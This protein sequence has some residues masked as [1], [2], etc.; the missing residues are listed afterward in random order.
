M[1]VMLCL[2]PS[3]INS[4]FSQDITVLIFITIISSLASGTK[5]NLVSSDQLS[6]LFLHPIASVPCRPRHAFPEILHDSRYASHDEYDS[7][8]AGIFA[9]TSIHVQPTSPSRLFVLLSHK[10]INGRDISPRFS[11]QM[12]SLNQRHGRRLSLPSPNIE[13]M[14]S[15]FVSFQHSSTYTL[16]S[17]DLN[18]R[19]ESLNKHNF[20][21]KIPLLSSSRTL[22]LT[23]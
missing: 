1:L 13:H 4:N 7:H 23:R 3:P 15:C 9:Q 18:A 12:L 6:S 17:S 16:T 22:D 20:R 14:V 11:C 5:T 21:I 19:N 8:R 2:S 10:V